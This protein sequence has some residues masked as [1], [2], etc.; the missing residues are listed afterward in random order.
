MAGCGRY[1][2]S[3]RFLVIDHQHQFDDYHHHNNLN[4]LNH[5]NHLDYSTR[6]LGI[7]YLDLE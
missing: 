4:H 3:L 7:V 1:H 2:R 5:L 6:L